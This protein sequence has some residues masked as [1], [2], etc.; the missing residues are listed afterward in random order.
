MASWKR[1]ALTGRKV[2]KVREVM[3]RSSFLISTLILAMS[4]AWFAR[5]VELKSR[6][7]SS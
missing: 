5:A 2:Q 6:T 3:H 7:D 4:L 1:V